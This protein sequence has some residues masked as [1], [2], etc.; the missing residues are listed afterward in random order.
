MLTKAQ[1]HRGSGALASREQALAIHLNSQIQN[2]KGQADAYRVLMAAMKAFCQQQQYTANEIVASLRTYIPDEGEF[3]KWLGIFQAYGLV[4]RPQEQPTVLQVDP[5]PQPAP[6]QATQVSDCHA[7]LYKG[8]IPFE[9]A[10]SS[11]SLLWIAGSESGKTT[12][13]VAIA[14]AIHCYDQSA[15]FFFV[16]LQ[17][18]PFLGLEEYAEIFDGKSIEIDTEPSETLS[19]VWYINGDGLAKTS[20][21]AKPIRWLAQ[22]QQRRYREKQKARREGRNPPKWPPLWLFVNEWGVLYRA[23]S[24]L[25]G[26]DRKRLDLPGWTQDIITSGREVGVRLC[27]TFH[28]TTADATGFKP[29]V[30]RSAVLISSGILHPSGNGS[31]ESIQSVVGNHHLIKSAHCRE[32]LRAVLAQGIN[33]GMPLIFTSMGLPRV[34]RYQDHS[35][36][37]ATSITKSHGG[38]GSYPRQYLPPQAMN[39]PLQC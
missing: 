21:A 36:C 16:D 26:A 8:D 29:D 34:G 33:Q 17:A 5:S 3:R 10:K 28:E 20:Q 6:P 30:L 37:R 9:V 12:G 18:S 13:M 1:N 23:W 25:S 7:E 2:A 24:T 38:V 39:F 15:R 14:Y 22:E 31:Y 35:Q 11:R 32:T 4:P 19:P 27:A